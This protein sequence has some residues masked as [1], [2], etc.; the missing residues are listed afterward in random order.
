MTTTSS[1]DD[2]E[3]SAGAIAGIVI[4]VIVAVISVMIAVIAVSIYW[5]R[6]RR[7]SFL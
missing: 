1:D 5:H 3:L 6:R 7:L 4:A 2:T